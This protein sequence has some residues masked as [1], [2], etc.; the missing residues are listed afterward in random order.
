MEDTLFK[1]FIKRTEGSILVKI[2]ELFH[3]LMKLILSGKYETK[4][5]FEDLERVVDRGKV[6]GNEGFYHLYGCEDRCNVFS[7]FVKNDLLGK[8]IE[9]INHQMKRVSNNIEAEE[10]SQILEKEFG[11]KIVEKSDIL[12][13]TAGCLCC[14]FEGIIHE[15]KTISLEE[16]QRVIILLRMSYYKDDSFDI[17]AKK[18]G[19]NLDEILIIGNVRSL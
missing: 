2:M 17:E 6:I 14:N 9:H 5:I 13:F 7:E 18:R 10:W 1:E 3:A 16:Y 19:I 15:L 12:F 11:F 4:L 8:K